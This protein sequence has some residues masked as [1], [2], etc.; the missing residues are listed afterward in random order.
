MPDTIRFERERGLLTLFA[1]RL[2]SP[3]AIAVLSG[4]INRA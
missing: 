4:F 1:Q 3:E 2:R